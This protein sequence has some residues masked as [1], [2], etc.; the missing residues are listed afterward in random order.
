MYFAEGASEHDIYTF[1]SELNKALKEKRVCEN[2]LQIYFALDQPLWKKQ[3]DLRV[4]CTREVLA[5]VIPGDTF[6]IDWA[7]GAVWR[8]RAD[9]E[10]M[11][12][13]MSFKQSSNGAFRD[14]VC[15][16]SS[17]RTSRLP[18]RPS[19]ADIV[20]HTQIAVHY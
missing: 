17:R 6:T 5:D 1:T 19:S 3:R 13:Y 20:P 11:L 4:R 10:P 14:G 18:S 2:S 7:T 12:V 8:E 15:S 16:V 9:A